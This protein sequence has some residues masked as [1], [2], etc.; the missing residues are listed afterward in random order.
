MK[1][2]KLILLHLALLY[3]IILPTQ[4]AYALPIRNHFKKIVYSTAK[5]IYSPV[6]LITGYEKHEIRILEENKNTARELAN[7]ATD[8]FV[9]PING[10]FKEGPRRCREKWNYEAYHPEKPEEKSKSRAARMMPAQEIAG[11]TSGLHKSAKNLE[12]L[13]EISVEKLTNKKT[14][15]FI[16]RRTCIL[17]ENTEELKNIIDNLFYIFLG[18]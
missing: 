9:Y 4:K 16:G 12:D 13:L 14:A 18:D 7:H 8:V 1:N 2:K 17:E 15:D 6:K 3:T 10:I 5:I 11:I